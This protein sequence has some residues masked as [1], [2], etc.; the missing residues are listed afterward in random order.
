MSVSYQRGEYKKYSELYTIIKDCIEGEL[1][2]KYKK[3]DYLPIVGDPVEDDEDSARYASYLQRAVFY[4]VTE[5]TLEGLSGEV[6]SVDPMIE[7]PLEIENLKEDINGMKISLI[8]QA[9][10]ALEMNLSYGRGGL[11]ID[12]PDT[13][14]SLTLKELSDSGIKPTIKL[15]EPLDII[16]WF[17][18]QRGSEN[19]LFLVVIKEEVETLIQFE[20]EKE[21]Q[22]RVLRL[23]LSEGN[24]IT[25]MIDDDNIYTVE[26]WRVVDGKMGVSESY[27][28]KDANGKYF[29]TLRF[30]FFGAQN[31]DVIVDRPPLGDLAIMNIHHYM[32]SAD[33]EESCHIV[34]QPTPYTTGLTEH[35]VN[36]VMNG[37][38]TLGSRAAVALPVGGDA[39]LIQ[40]NP[41]TLPFEAMAH[42]ERQMVSMGARIVE[43]RQVQRTA[44]ETSIE[45]SAEKSILTTVADNVSDAY[46]SALKKALEF[47]VVSE[48][49]IV[50]SLNT[51][52]RLANLS[53]DEQSKV[54]AAWQNGALSFTE[55][56]NN[57]RHAG[58]KL[59]D[60]EIAKNEIE[61]AQNQADER[62][63]KKAQAI[64]PVVDGV[65]N[66]N[67]R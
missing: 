44:T 20:V 39:G 46:R 55:M 10:D 1:A 32:N 30:D 53:V 43:Q 40:A 22:Y 35:W 45:V 19:I 63:I 61:Q 11:F 49:D 23:G 33:Y 66:N 12:Y 67:E 64:K 6:F 48:N 21:I 28:P 52:F 60:D 5:R 26:I 42:K 58:L 51:N 18:I 17:S 9:K 36:E 8:Q 13:G 62:E 65:N 4:N 27:Q 37:T 57:L 15:I 31:N 34:G 2:V 7:L 47:V 41:N 29:N 14:G 16:N 59:D 24:S 25:G 50:F 3:D 56:R 38:L 54:I